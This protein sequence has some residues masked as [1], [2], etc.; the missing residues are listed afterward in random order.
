MLT[1]PPV[2]RLLRAIRT[3]SDSDTDGDRNTGRLITSDPNRLPNTFGDRHRKSD[4]FRVGDLDS[5]T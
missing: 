3:T 1:A 2:S 5:I 4:W